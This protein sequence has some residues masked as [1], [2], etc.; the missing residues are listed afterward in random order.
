MNYGIAKQK[1]TSIRHTTFYFTLFHFAFK[2]VFNN[3]FVH[4][5]IPQ[6]ISTAKMVPY[7]Y[8]NLSIWKYILLC[9][10]FSW[11]KYPL[12]WVFL[13]I[14]MPPLFLQVSSKGIQAVHIIVP[15]VLEFVQGMNFSHTIQKEVQ[16][17]L[18]IVNWFFSPNF[19]TNA[20]NFTIQIILVLKKWRTKSC[21]VIAK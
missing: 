3:L 20:K 2:C 17:K 8:C 1:H 15:L 21:L 16:W 5:N 10:K 19:F 6:P 11:P 9:K 18:V 7:R 12:F 14:P 4:F 13:A